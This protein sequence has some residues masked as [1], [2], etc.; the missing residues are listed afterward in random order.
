MEFLAKRWYWNTSEVQNCL[1][2]LENRSLITKVFSEGE[3]DITLHPKNIQ[4]CAVPHMG[5][6]PQSKLGSKL[7][8]PNQAY[9]D[10]RLW[11]CKKSEEVC[12]QDCL[13]TLK[14]NQ[15]ITSIAQIAMRWNCSKKMAMCYLSIFEA[16]GLIIYAQNTESIIIKVLPELIQI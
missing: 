15:L 2:Q 5:I 14:S 4:P 13:I 9:Y 1:E 11:S 16:A 12:F 10:L 8:A 3:I 6:I 7:I